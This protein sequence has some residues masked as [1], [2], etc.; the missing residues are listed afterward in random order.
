MLHVNKQPPR[1]DTLLDRHD[2][3]YS[4][5]LEGFDDVWLNADLGWHIICGIGQVESSFDYQV[6]LF[7]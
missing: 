5:L 7:S 6:S 2:E 4:T 3:S 1:L